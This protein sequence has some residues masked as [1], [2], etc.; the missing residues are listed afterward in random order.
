ML[1]FDFQRYL[2]VTYIVRVF[3]SLPESCL[4]W[5]GLKELSVSLY[6]LYNKG[7]TDP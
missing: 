7:V 2:R 5:Q 6:K 1:Y 4:F 3:A